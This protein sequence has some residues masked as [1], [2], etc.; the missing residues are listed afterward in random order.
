MTLNTK[1]NTIEPDD[2]D[3]G[4]V[5]VSKNS[6]RIWDP[7]MWP[8]GRVKGTIRNRDGK[9]LSGVT[10]QAFA[11]DDKDKRESS[12]LRVAKTALDG[13]YTLEPLPSGKYVI[14][15][16]GEMS[17]DEDV[18]PPTFYSGAKAIY[19]S[20]SGTLAGIDITLPAGRKA[21]Q[22]HVTVLGPDGRPHSGATVYLE[23]LEGEQR[24]FSNDPSDAYGEVR[25]PVYLGERYVVRSFDTALQGAASLEV[26]DESPSVTITLHREI[27]Q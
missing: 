4:L 21:G 10:V 25:A 15:V 27:T 14:G 17:K 7:A 18:Y 20:E 6:C 12:P 26:A 11:F 24:W 5:D 23:N 2:A 19:L 13:A 16:N 9:P 8:A 22:L 1:T 3:P